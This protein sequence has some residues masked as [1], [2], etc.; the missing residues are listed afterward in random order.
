VKTEGT[1]DQMKETSGVGLKLNISRKNG[2][3]K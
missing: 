1:P 3:L 2:W